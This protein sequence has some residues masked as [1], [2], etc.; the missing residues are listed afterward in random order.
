MSWRDKLRPASF[1]GVPFFIE[2]HDAEEGRRVEVH[3]YPLRDEP[4]VEDLGKKAGTYSVAAYVLGADYMDARDRLREACNQ[5]GAAELVHPYLGAM[6]AVC[7]AMRLSESSFD[8]GMARFDLT[9]VEA[10]KSQFPEAKEDAA[11]SLL[12]SADKLDAATEGSFADRFSVDGWPDW[13]R[14]DALADLAGQINRLADVGNLLP[15]KEVARFALGIRQLTGSL[16][17]LLSVP[18]Q[19]AGQVIGMFTS[20]TGSFRNPLDGIA[21]LKSRFAR[22]SVQRQPPPAVSST[23]TPAQRQAALNTQAVGALFEQA[24]ISAAAATAVARPTAQGGASALP[25]NPDSG[26]LFE[27]VDQAIGQRDELGGWIDE[28]LPT[29][30][31]AVYLALTDLR[32]ALYQAL[33]DAESDLPRLAEYRPVRSL[34]ALTLAYAIHG[35]ARR[36]DE[37]VRHNPTPYPGFMPS[38]ALRVLTD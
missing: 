12:D 25:L 15:I 11:A 19:L 3:E 8:G 9:F 38:A 30:P 1:R 6:Q 35:D 27:S 7:T 36:A 14:A 18:D 17:T 4:Y 37:L 29:A 32:V 26:G 28:L 21:A 23:Q 10:G 22:T 33:P 20:L 5:P 24:A 2:S 34:P 31:D 13:A 16:E